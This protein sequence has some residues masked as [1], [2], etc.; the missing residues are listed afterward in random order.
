MADASVP[1][2]IARPPTVAKRCGKEKLAA[3]D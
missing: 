2:V 3:A 1:G